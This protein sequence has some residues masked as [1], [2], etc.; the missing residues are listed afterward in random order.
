MY[1]FKRASNEVEKFES[2]I[3]RYT[4]L[5]MN[6]LITKTTKILSIYIYIYIY[7]YICQPYYIYVM[8]A[9]LRP[10]FAIFAS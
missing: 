6:E 1:K 4:E 7:I 3:F 2:I 5:E 9:L 10:N 8:L